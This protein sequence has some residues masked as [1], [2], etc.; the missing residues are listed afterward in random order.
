MSTIYRTFGFLACATALVVVACSDDESPETPNGAA[1][2]G[3]GGEGQG[4]QPHGEAGGPLG[5][6]GEPHGEGPVECEALGS[7]CHEGDTGTP[8]AVGNCHD[9]GHAGD[10]DVCK[11]QFAACI[12]VCVADDT[13]A[14]GAPPAT[15][16]NPYCQALGSLCHFV[17]DVGTPTGDCHD[18]GH[19][20]NEPEC[21]EAFAGC[22]P[23]CLEKRELEPDDHDAGGA[24]GA[25]SDDHSGG[26]DAVAGAGGAGG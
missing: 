6:A 18:V 20:G 24:G 7:I 17:D 14:G 16:E 10:G 9:V 2:S 22:V 13:G 4:G 23:I 21:I 5:I 1:G 15:V 26:A 25:G 8:S 3:A 12:T 11:D 19:L